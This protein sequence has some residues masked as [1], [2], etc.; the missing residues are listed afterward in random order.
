MVGASGQYDAAQVVLLHVCQGAQAFLLHVMLEDL[1]FFIGGVDGLLRFLAGH[2][3]PCEF[4]DDAV[5]HELVV[6]EIEVRVHVA[7]ARLVQ[8]RHVRADHTRIV[9]HD[10]AVEAVVHAL[11]VKV[12]E[13]HAR[14]EDRRV[15]LVE[16]ILDMAVGEFRRIADV[17]GGDG[18]DAFFEQ[19]VV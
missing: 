1:V 18:I 4:L 14:I 2:V 17:L 16:Q 3:R 15:A 19:L 12:F 7:D 10:R 8:L 6:G 11:H 9:G 13:V 5:D